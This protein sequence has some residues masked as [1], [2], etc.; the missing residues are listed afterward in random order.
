MHLSRLGISCRSLAVAGPLAAALLLGSAAGGQTPTDDPK[1][2]LEHVRRLNE[3][4][5]Q[6][7][8]GDVRA[9]L[10]EA[11]RLARTDTGAAAEMLGRVLRDLDADTSLTQARR[12]QLAKTVSE[13][14]RQLGRTPER[15]AERREAAPPLPPRRP[16]ANARQPADEEIGRSLRTIRSL[17]R[18]GR[19][20]EARQ[21]AEELARQLP[22]NAAAQAARRNVDAASTLSSIRG[23]RA[24]GEQRLSALQRDLGRSS[25][26]PGGDLDF[27]KDW[28]EKSRKRSATVQLTDREK[29]ILKALAAPVSVDFNGTKFEDAINEL[30]K[31]SGQPI[32]LDRA[33]LEEAQITYETPVTLRA[34]GMGL[35]TILRQILGRFS[36]AY[37]I[38]DQAL[39]VTTE[40]RAK[41]MMVVRSYYI[42][43][44]LANSGVGIFDL[45]QRFEVD[46]LQMAKQA[47]QIIEMIE[48]SIEPMS[49]QKNGGGGT[50][51]FNAATGSLIVK[52]SA[53]VHARLAGG[54]SP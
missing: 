14:I 9:A 5:A 2:Y 30:S 10:R 26:P 25:M 3:V 40:A 24:D 45:A 22:D 32:V 44:L 38:R 16:L 53:E 47:A 39:E 21:R 20:A 15:I 18:D 50:I 52:Q 7:I 6:K 8:E 23:D 27:P 31:A 29:A 49:W 54:L 4:A 13:R 43:D 35:R 34:N 1:A 46:P 42:G 17:Q 28:A 48:T 11:Q 36:L 51:T 41:E 12:D 19:L 33:A 37:V